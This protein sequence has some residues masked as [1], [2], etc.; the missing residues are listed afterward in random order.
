M[1]RLTGLTVVGLYLAFMT[2]GKDL[3]P[4]EHAAWDTRKDDRSSL[5]TMMSDAMAQESKRQGDYV[6]VLAEGAAA[7]TKVSAKNVVLASYNAETVSD[8][9]KLAA[10]T[11]T[12]A[13]SQAA[14]TA[15]EV[16]EDKIIVLRE[17]TGKRVNVRSGPSTNNAVLGQ[18]VNAEIVQLLTVPK[19][20]W[21]K[22]SVQGDGVEGYMSTKFLTRVAQ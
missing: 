7:P 16:V 13:T 22:I 5:M 11:D 3:S 8:P 19:D 4:E 14:A 17:V 9:S 21:V 12:S 2:F 6:P 15:P 18:V 20:G 10:L 1:L